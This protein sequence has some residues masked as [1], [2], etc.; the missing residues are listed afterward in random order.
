MAIIAE[1]G[2]NRPMRGKREGLRPSVPDR[3]YILVIDVGGTHVKFRVG[4]RGA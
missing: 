4:V 2:E 1:S 3:N